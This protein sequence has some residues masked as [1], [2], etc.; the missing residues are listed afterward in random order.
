MSKKSETKPERV[1]GTGA[2]GDPENPELSEAQIAEQQS[3]ADAESTT[4]LEHTASVEEH[5]TVE[6]GHVQKHPTETPDK[7][8]EDA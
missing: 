6:D 2:K 3:E 1:L 5:I 4:L 8:E 7:S